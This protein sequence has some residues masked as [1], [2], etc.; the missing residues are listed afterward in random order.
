MAESFARLEDTSSDPSKS[1]FLFERSARTRAVGRFPMKEEWE[2]KGELDV[3]ARESGE[4]P[5]H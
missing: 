1:H 3:R 2:S 4:T 5:P